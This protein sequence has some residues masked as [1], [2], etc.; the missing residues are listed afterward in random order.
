MTDPRED[1]I[2]EVLMSRAKIDRASFSRDLTLESMGLESLDVIEAVFELEDEFH[3]NIPFNANADGKDS[4]K[5]T[6]DV[7][8][9][10]MNLIAAEEPAPVA[11][12]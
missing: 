11:A 4:L 2:I 10:V 12:K 9:L 6:G 3:I 1:Q 5:T 7:I 8:D